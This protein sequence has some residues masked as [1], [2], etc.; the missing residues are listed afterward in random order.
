MRNIFRFT[1]FYRT[2]YD[3][4]CSIKLRITTFDSNL[5]M[6]C[7]ERSV[8]KRKKLIFNN[9]TLVFCRNI[10]F[11]LLDECDQAS[12]INEIAQHG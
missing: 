5:K 1:L 6:R 3:P 11:L 7:C 2:A 12:T 8:G 9:C 10:K 4:F